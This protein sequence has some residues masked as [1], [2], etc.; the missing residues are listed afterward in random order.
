VPIYHPSI[1]ERIERAKMGKAGV[2]TV[3]DRLTRRSARTLARC[4]FS[5]GEIAIRQLIDEID[6]SKLTK[7]QKVVL[8]EVRARMGPQP[9]DT[10]GAPGQ[11]LAVSSCLGLEER[12]IRWPEVQIGNSGFNLNRS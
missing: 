10:S 6:T 4:E 12:I 7:V 8:M 5:V 1:Y 9:I 2:L 3:A 11:P